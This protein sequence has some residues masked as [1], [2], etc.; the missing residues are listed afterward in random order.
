MANARKKTTAKIDFEKKFNERQAK[1]GAGPMTLNEEETKGMSAAQ[2]GIALEKAAEAGLADQLGLGGDDIPEAKVI[3]NKE[4]D[5]KKYAKKVA[6]TLYA[7]DSPFHIDKFFK[8]L[9]KD[10]GKH[11]KSQQ[12]K[13]I[14]DNLQTLFNE[15][16][17][18]ERNLDKNVKT[19]KAA[20]KGGGGKGFDRN[21]NAAMI[22]DVLGNDEY[23][24]YGEE[25]GFKREEE[26]DYD[27][28]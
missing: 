26:A 12:I 24:D 1:S 4:A 3:L 9:A 16:V 25:G 22:N 23:G 13:G 27:F 15:K 17:K 11:C 2:K 7:G 18:E 21:N 6:E 5:Y 10:I 8:E 20:L 14:A 28:M 19:K